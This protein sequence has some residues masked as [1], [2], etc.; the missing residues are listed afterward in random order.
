MKNIRFC[1][2]IF[3]PVLIVEFSIYL[4]KSV[5]VMCSLSFCETAGGVFVKFI[6]HVFAYL[7]VCSN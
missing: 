6:K 3:F 7:P 4:N 5:F 2:L 1:Y